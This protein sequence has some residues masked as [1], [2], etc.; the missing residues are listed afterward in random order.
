MSLLRHCSSSRA[1]LRSVPHLPALSNAQSFSL[2]FSAFHPFHSSPLLVLSSPEPLLLL[3]SPFSCLFSIAYAFLPVFLLFFFLFFL[4]FTQ[5][6]DQSLKTLFLTP[7][8]L[9][10]NK[11][12]LPGDPRKEKLGEMVGSSLYCLRPQER[13]KTFVPCREIFFSRSVVCQCEQGHRL[14]WAGPLPCESI[15][16]HQPW[17]S[18]PCFPAS[19]A[20]SWYLP[21]S[22]VG[23]PQTSLGSIALLIPQQVYTSTCH[24]LSPPVGTKPPQAHQLA[25]SQCLLQTLV[26][27]C[28]LLGGNLIPT[29]LGPFFRAEIR[30]GRPQVAL[31]LCMGRKGP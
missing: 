14:H 23:T 12:L 31:C 10:G 30:R 13:I 17:P 28:R 4:S 16:L 19:E 21:S 7:W 8:G 22:G 15:P 26:Y 24:A 27:V 3:F 2:L 29:G 20:R 5:G 25:H 6:D 18:P 9:L 11:S 1:Y